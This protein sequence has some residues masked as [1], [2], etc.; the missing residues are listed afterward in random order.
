MFHLWSFFVKLGELEIVPN[1][2]KEAYLPE[3][4]CY[5]ERN[6]SFCTLCGVW[7]DDFHKKFQILEE[8][9]FHFV[10]FH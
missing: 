3:M 6:L 1:C 2:L 10:L 5:K 4:V 7:G 9:S 8:Q